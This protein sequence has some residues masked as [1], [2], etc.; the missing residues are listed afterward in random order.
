MSRLHEVCI[1][2]VLIEFSSLR[3]WYTGMTLGCYKGYSIY[4]L[5]V[6]VNKNIDQRR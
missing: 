1:R 3:W 4:K 6:P 2:V 5:D